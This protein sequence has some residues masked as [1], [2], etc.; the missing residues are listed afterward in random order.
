VEIQTTQTDADYRSRV[1]SVFEYVSSYALSI[2]TH[3]LIIALLFF[4]FPLLSPAG[5]GGGGSGLGNGAISVSLVNSMSGLDRSGT[6]GVSTTGSETQTAVP[7]KLPDRV[8]ENRSRNDNSR[9][10]IPAGKEIRP[11]KSSETA[12]SESET[13][14]PEKS[15][16]QAGASGLG[17]ANPGSGIGT[18][19]GNGIGSGEGSGVGSGKGNGMGNGEGDGVGDGI[20]R[21][22]LPAG[23]L[24]FHAGFDYCGKEDA[25]NGNVVTYSIEYK[26]GDTNPEVV[27]S[28]SEYKATDITMNKVK[29]FIL[30]SFDSSVLVT[31]RKTLFTGTI[32]C[33]CATGKCRLMSK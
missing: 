10:T 29:N 6:D 21:S 8:T 30:K 12:T 15:E 5:G 3:G 22:Y 23:A 33:S 14:K 2:L 28:G 27:F 20:G 9:V 11:S 31:E 13:G 16:Q 4:L 7:N 26:T 25:D 19:K 32:K 1:R 18:G 24:S 17:D